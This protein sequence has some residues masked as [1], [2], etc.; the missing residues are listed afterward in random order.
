VRLA[1]AQPT[2]YLPV[3]QWKNGLIVVLVLGFVATP[4]VFAGLLICLPISLL[5]I[6]VSILLI[7]QQVV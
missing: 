1:Q 7:E 5:L 3:E 2:W 6:V 4:N